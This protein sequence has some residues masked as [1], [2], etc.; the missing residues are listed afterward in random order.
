MLR[1]ERERKEKKNV[2]HSGRCW[3]TNL[4]LVW[5]RSDSAQSVCIF[6]LRHTTI[7]V[8]LF[9][10]IDRNLGEMSEVFHM[11]DIERK[12]ERDE[13]EERGILLP[14]AQQPQTQAQSQALVQMDELG[15]QTG[16][17]VTSGPSREQYSIFIQLEWMD[18]GRGWN[19]TT[20]GD[21][22]YYR[23]LLIQWPRVSLCLIGMFPETGVRAYHCPLLV[24]SNL[25]LTVHC[26]SGP[27]KGPKTDIQLAMNAFL[28]TSVMDKP[29]YK[30]FQEKNPALI[31]ERYRVLY[32]H[33]VYSRS[34]VIIDFCPRMI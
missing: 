4:L 34:H 26:Y 30:G 2:R 16:F 20:S 29:G 15:Y 31:L 14:P 17:R 3:M 11:N 23:V 13:R 18:S 12:R 22:Y 32:S 24:V 28:W 7:I 1:E 33:P 19:P 8:P 9:A 27:E 10:G 6:I 5:F 21:K 25:T